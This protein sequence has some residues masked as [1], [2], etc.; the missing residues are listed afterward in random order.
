MHW[1]FRLKYFDI[2]FQ[3]FTIKAMEGGAIEIWVFKLDE[4]GDSAVGI[5]TGRASK[6]ERMGGII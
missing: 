5:W 6:V 4:D 3:V 1:R 2:L